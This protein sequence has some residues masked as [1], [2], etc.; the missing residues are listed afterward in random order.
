MDF[1]KALRKSSDL[2]QECLY[3]HLFSFALLRKKE[4]LVKIITP[5]KWTFELELIF[6]QILMHLQAFQTIIL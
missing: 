1:T 5:H 6:T 3:V 4:Q 2:L